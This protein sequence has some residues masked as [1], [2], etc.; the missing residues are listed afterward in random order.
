MEPQ[1]LTDQHLVL[2]SQRIFSEP[3]RMRLGSALGLKSHELQSVKT[4][5]RREITTAAYEML[6]TWFLNMD[7][8]VI[9]HEKLVEALKKANLKLLIKQVLLPKQK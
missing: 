2:L 8:E 6:L 4:N 7:N 3:I 9:A 5:N 1:E